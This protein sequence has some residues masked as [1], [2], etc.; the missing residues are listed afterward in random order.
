MSYTRR[1]TLG[2]LLGALGMAGCSSGG[3]GRSAAGETLRVSASLGEHEWQ[4]L[5]A[6]VFPPF[7]ARERCRIAAVNI[8]AADTLKKLEA[9]HRANRMGL[10]LLLLDNMHLAPYVE[11]R[12][13]LDLTQYQA[14][15]DPAVDA[16]LVT[17]LTFHGRLM[18]FPGRPNVQ[19]T[20]YNT[21]VFNGR[22]YAIPETWD[23]LL[24]VAKRL[25]AAY[26]VGKVAVHGTLDTNTTAQVFEFVIAAGGEITTLNDAGS[27]K[28]FTFLQE[29]YPYLSPETKKANWNTTNKFLSEETVFLARNWPV[30]MQV[31]VQQNRKTNI[32]AFATWAGTAGRAT[33]IGGDVIAIPKRAPHQELAL[34]FAAYWMSREVQTRLVTELGWPPIRSDA[35]GSVP[36]WQQG[37]FEATMDALR[38]GHYRPAI[39]GWSAVDK[40]VN[41]AFQDIV[42]DGRDVQATLDRY[43]RE[44]QEELEWLT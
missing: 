18:F 21:D 43:A 31:I 4:V 33:M 28:A 14:L 5:R 30:G 6:H 42:M 29:L 17:P 12:L 27:V 15:I 35:L 23:E 40:Y 41:L 26:Q 8:E 10:D 44:L 36:A 34:T 22:T 37:F 20:Y 24:D 1:A 7:E 32:K 9:M 11:K 13:V 19:I 3:A 38:H 16:S 25:K 2:L 39:M